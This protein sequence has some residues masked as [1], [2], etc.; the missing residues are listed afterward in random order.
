ME[1]LKSINSKKIG[2]NF[3]ALYNRKRILSESAAIS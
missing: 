2:I 1:E 3:I